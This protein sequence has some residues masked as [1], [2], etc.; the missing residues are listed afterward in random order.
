MSSDSQGNS[1]WRSRYEASIDQQKLEDGQRKS[2]PLSGAAGRF[3]GG[4][5][6]GFVAALY[7]LFT[8]ENPLLAGFMAIVLGA[9]LLMGLVLLMKSGKSARSEGSSPRNGQ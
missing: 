6:A 3:W 9:T 8:S 2:D 1:D 7:W 4:I 5:L